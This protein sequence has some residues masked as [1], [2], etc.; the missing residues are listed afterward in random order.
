[1]SLENTIEEL[2][3]KQLKIM[4]TGEILVNWNK[5]QDLQI[6]ADGRSLKRTDE[7]KILMLAE[8]MARFGIVNNL[9]V[10]VDDKGIPYCFDAHHRKKAFSVLNA[11]GIIIPELPATRCLAESKDEAKKLL[12]I[13]ESRS[14]WVD[15]EVVPD[16]IKEIGLSVEIASATVDVPELIWDDLKKEE[17]PE[18]S[19]DDEYSSAT[20]EKPVTKLG[21]LWELGPHRVLCGDST[22]EKDVEKLMNG[23][24]AD[25]V[26][27]DPPYGVDYQSNMRTK[28][29][30]FEK[31]KNDDKKLEFM[32][33]LEK[34]SGG[35]V[36]IWTTWKVVNQWIEKTKILGFP[37]N[38]II[39]F[40]GGRGI[41]DL[42]KTFSTDYEIALVFNRGAE[43]KGKRI[44]SVW[45]I[46]KD[47]AIN[48]EHPTQK[49]VFLSEEAIDKTTERRSKI[50]D[51]FLGSGA[52]LI[53]C[54]KTD[55]ICYG[56]ELAPQYVDVIVNRY[57]N[58]CQ[59]NGR[60][61]DV[62]LN[63]EPHAWK[64]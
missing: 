13:K 29:E 42:K 6:T 58:W 12:F 20:L 25:M 62:K 11:H 35:W 30:K 52:T 63:G 59:E 14:S 38:M 28:S 24:K 47:G 23:V 32:P 40:K 54:E 7:N 15:I 36:F 34:F 45:T 37:S 21:D 46:R 3:L 22:K 50:L 18:T 53:A 2:K 9:Q 41:G 16:Y 8:S 57:V 60:P 51:L 1:M 44:G 17:E 55:R 26:F 19:G 5:L 27:T 43:L 33:I 39:W 31:I 64:N 56:M 49:P 10:W 61:Y 48:Y 4:C